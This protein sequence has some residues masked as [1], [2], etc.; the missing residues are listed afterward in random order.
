MQMV[1]KLLIIL[2]S[3]WIAI[4]VFMPKKELYYLLEHQIVKYNV[5]LNEKT[6]TDTLFG[7]DL[8]KV[9]VYMSGI[10]LAQ[11]SNIKFITFLFYNKVNL[12][13]L[14]IDNSLKSVVP[15]NIKDINITYS[16]VSPMQLDISADGD[17]GEVKGYL[18]INRTIH[19]DFIKV[20]NIKSLKKE[21]KKNKNGWYYENRI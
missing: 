14:K 2:I 7:L 9:D 13:Q 8:N 16:I 11:I 19:L 21:L 4:I 5:K 15:L 10:N 1:K 20:G 6:I 3:I 12:N 18:D 17:F